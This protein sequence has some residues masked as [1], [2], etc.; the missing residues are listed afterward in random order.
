MADDTW[1][2][3]LREIGD[4][5][6]DH[7]TR[8]QLGSVLAFLRKQLG[9]RAAV[10][11]QD[12]QV[13]AHDGQISARFSSVSDAQAV[14]LCELAAE[15]GV[16]VRVDDTRMGPFRTQ[17]EGARLYAVGYSGAIAVPLTHRGVDHG[18]IVLWF[19]EE[20]ADDIDRS[21]LPANYILSAVRQMLTLAFERDNRSV[22]PEGALTS[23]GEV[24]RLASLGL[25][26]DGALFALRAPSSSML[27]QIDELRRQTDEIDLLIDPSDHAL[28]DA[29]G[30]LSQTI[31]DLTLASSLLR[32]ELTSLSDMSDTQGGKE[33]VQ[34]SRL[35][36]ESMVIARPELEQRGFTLRE[37]I[38]NDCYMHGERHELLHLAL[39]LLFAW[40]RDEKLA[41]RRPVLEIQLDQLENRCVIRVVS[42]S[43]DNYGDPPSPPAA[44][45]RI[46]DAH[47]GTLS[48]RSGI[49]EVSFPIQESAAQPTASAAP[50]VRQVLIIDDDPMF[51]RALRRALTPHD[52]RVCGT[53]AEAEIALME[54]SYSPDLVVC[55]LWLPGTNGRALHE[56]V[57]AHQPDVA[58]RFVFVS[59][60][61]VSS[62][63]VRYF[64]E[65]GCLTLAKPIQVSDLLGMLDSEPVTPSG[66][67]IPYSRSPLEP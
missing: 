46:V 8:T 65:A 23:L 66:R 25:M 39:G 29:L 34:M 61:S 42:R 47:Q 30:E 52:V 50:R 20:F 18:G 35:I 3:K 60:A 36:H 49:I 10:A 24:N 58:P 14:L 12:G 28:G 15:R 33:S 26:L 1:D 22:S 62:K 56:R 11:T 37:R 53:A 32:K 43:A 31:D 41:S 27:I 4:A 59:G 17:E 54:A 57:A 63:D 55:D 6:I 64:K 5:L 38:I 7:P 2:E 9:A 44:C 67:A 16:A 51:A 21:K 13:T 48:T 19:G 45:L 40:T